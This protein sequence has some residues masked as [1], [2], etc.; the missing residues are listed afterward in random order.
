MAG[1]YRYGGFIRS[2]RPVQDASITLSEVGSSF[3]FAI[4]H[5]STT[6]T[7][8]RV[9]ANSVTFFY[10]QETDFS[11]W[12]KNLITIDRGTFTVLAKRMP[13]Q[14]PEPASG[15]APGRGSP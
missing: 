12:G 15:L 8:Y 14:L 1:F 10:Q 7:L 5:I 2:C 4:P 11:S 3:S 6:Y 9:E 13:S